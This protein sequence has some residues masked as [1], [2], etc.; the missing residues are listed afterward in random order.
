MIERAFSEAACAVDALERASPPLE[1]LLE[2]GMAIVR[3]LLIA[4][5]H[6]AGKAMVEDEDILRVFKA[7]VK[8][9]P[10]LNAIRDSVRELVFMQNCLRLGRPDALPPRPERMAVRL[11]RHIALYLQSRCEQS[12]WLERS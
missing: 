12:G 4:Y 1:T 9:D 11:V 2:E 7:F 10:S 3:G 6:R 8:G 5:G